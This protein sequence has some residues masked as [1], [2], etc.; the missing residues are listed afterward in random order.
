MTA[1]QENFRQQYKE[2]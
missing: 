1:D 2:I